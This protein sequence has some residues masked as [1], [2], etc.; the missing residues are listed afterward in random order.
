MF[1]VKLLLIQVFNS[2]H[3]GNLAQKQHNYFVELEPVR[4]T[5]YDRNSRPLAFNVPV[6]SLFANPR[7]MSEEEK[8]EAIEQLASVLGLEPDFLRERLVRDKYFVWLKRKLSSDLA[9]QIK[10][11]KIKGIGFRRESK[12]Y[13]P[14]G[15]LAAHVI[16]FAGT[17]NMGLEGLE[18]SYN[19]YLKGKE[20]KMQVLRDARQRQLQMGESFLPPRD[21]FHLV[22]TIDETIQYIAERAL[23]KAYKK[24]DAKAASIIVM[25]VETGEILALANQPTYDLDNVAQSNIENRTNRAI[26]Y[27]Y[28]PGS[29]FKIITAA[30]ALEEDIFTEEDKIYCENGKYRIANHILTDHREHGT[31]A[32]KDVFGLSSNIGVAKIAQKIGPD[33]VYKYGQRF[34]FGIPTGIDLNGEVSGWL[35]DPSQWS[36]TTIGAIPIGYEVTVT[37]LQLVCAISSIAN[38]G[39]YMRPFVVKYVKDNQGQHIKSFDPQIVDRAISPDTAR[40]VKEILKGVVETGTGKRAQIK[41]V[42]VAGKT[43]TARKVIDGKYVRGK[44]YASF[45]GFAP[46]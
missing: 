33:N 42:E 19:K 29:V 27:V 26:S 35:K 11:M 43:G 12:R 13:Y 28:E 6:Y 30:A 41:G 9:G 8:T 36:K 7:S 44:Y 37:P 4:G 2:S 17:D 23:Y 46:A 38:E 15:S 32:F 10:K 1:S 22:L 25:D 45:M 34:R 31:L 20:G 18:L 21:G 16:G 24:H 5:I 39:V 40:R 14:N 3:L